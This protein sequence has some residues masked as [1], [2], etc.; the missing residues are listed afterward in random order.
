MNYMFM[1]ILVT[2]GTGFI[3]SFLAEKLRAR[4]H[5]VWLT[6]RKNSSLHRLNDSS[7]FNFIDTDNEGWENKIVDIEPEAIF[8][9]ATCYSKQDDSDKVTN[10]IRTNV[11]FPCRILGCVADFSKIVFINTG[12]FFE[13]AP[14]DAPID[15]DWELR[16]FN[17]YAQTKIMFAS[18]LEN[19]SKY[20]GLRAVTLRLFSPYGPHDRQTKLLPFAISKF[21]AKEPF[22]MSSGEQKLDFTY[23]EDIIVAYIKSLEFALSKDEGFHEFFNI[24][25]GN[26]VSV[27][28][29][30]EELAKVGN[31]ECTAVFGARDSTEMMF[32]QANIN[33]AES[34]LGWSP[35]TN[36]AQG[37]EKTF[38][39]G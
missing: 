23:V 5:S 38:E 16:P 1:N 37:L 33:K 12:T 24:G 30:I 10:M 31:C 14:S 22:D 7:N 29:L 25:S 15:E 11:E 17:L 32:S 36:I 20:R 6:K 9:L 8:H 2:G 35:S 3:G 19:F 4:G 39:N 28:S 21:K 34:L 18:Y 27:R 13:Y 26:A